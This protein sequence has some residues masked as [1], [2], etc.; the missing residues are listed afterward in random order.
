MLSQRSLG[1]SGCN[2][3]TSRTRRPFAIALLAAG[4]RQAPDA[5]DL[6][7]ASPGSSRTWRSLAIHPS[8][9]LVLRAAAPR[10]SN[11]RQVVGSGV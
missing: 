6:P 11:Y 10:D 3:T 4:H 2:G 5:W 8:R 9:L 7:A 1:W